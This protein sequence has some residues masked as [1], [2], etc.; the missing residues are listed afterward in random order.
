[1]R[2]PASIRRLAEYCSRHV[3]FTRRLPRRFGSLRLRVS[4]GASLIYYRGLQQPN[5]D[6]LYDFAQ[7]H[8][9]SSHT[10]WD[11]G[12]N[13]GVLSF[14]AAARAGPAGRVLC[15]EPDLWSARL[16]LASQRM[17]RGLCAPLEVL[18]VAI[19]DTASLAR[20]QIPERSRAAAHLEITDGGSGGDI[21]GGVREQ[22][23]VSTV[24]L[25]WLAA[26][27]PPPDVLK[28]DVDGNE[29]RVLRGGL[30]LL[31]EKR[32]VIL[33]EVYERNA[34][35]VTALLHSLGYKLYDYSHGEQGKVLL[36]RT[37]YNTLA[38][39]PAR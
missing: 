4:P 23:L 22:F 26:Q 39:P 32:P 38:L 34:D 14:A 18:A 33:T 17:N 8:V 2:I 27:Y 19:S 36:T 10:V 12:S 21:T 1:M 3:F 28:I 16:L 5:F 13:M 30:A 25:D 35:E 29:A 37:A 6:D 31:R 15:I 7:H 24:T 20:L 11:V 9:Q